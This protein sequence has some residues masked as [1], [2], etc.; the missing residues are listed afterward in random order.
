MG[1]NLDQGDEAIC[2]VLLDMFL[3]GPKSRPIIGKVRGR[4]EFEYERRCNSDWE[5]DLL[6]EIS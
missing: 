6:D 4:L 5:E 2:E 1:Y 3:R